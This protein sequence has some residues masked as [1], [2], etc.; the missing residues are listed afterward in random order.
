MV[1]KLLIRDFRCFTRLELEFDHESTWIVG[2]NATGKTSLLEAVAVLTRLQSPRT[3]SLGQSIRVGAKGLVTDGLV[4]GYHLQFYYSATRRKLALDGVEQKNSRAY[5]ALAK[6]VYFANSDIVMVRGPAELRRRFLDFLGSQVFENYRSTLRSYE[7]ALL[8]RNRFLKMIPPRRR[9]VNAYSK[10][11][12]QFGARLSM[13]RASLIQQLDP[14]LALAFAAVSDRAETVSLAYQQGATADFEVALRE[15]EKEESRLMTTV[16]GPHRDDLQIILND[17]PAEIFASEGQQ[18]TIVIALKL[19]EAKLLELQ[20]NKPP[21]LL[22][23]DVFG[24]L[25]TARRNRLLATL[26][27]RGQRFITT[28]HLD[29]LES[30]PSGKVYR[31]VECER[32]DRAL[33]K[34]L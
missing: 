12:V 11:L 17:R 29:W 22:L 18:R 9:E 4:S 5:L 15:S 26:P 6:L 24:E 23:D 27:S 25:D 20:F 3:I 16:I 8:S 21:L 33:E 13:L 1:G 28:T 30:L 10:P 31:I 19:A 7:K 2:K 32:G 14:H 34:G